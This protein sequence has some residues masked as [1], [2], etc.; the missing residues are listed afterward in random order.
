[1]QTMLHNISLKVI[2]LY[3]FF[4]TQVLLSWWL[5]S[6][7]TDVNNTERKI[8]AS[9]YS[10]IIIISKLMQRIKEE[11]FKVFLWFHKGFLLFERYILRFKIILNLIMYDF[12]KNIMRVSSNL[13]TYFLFR[14]YKEYLIYIY[15]ICNYCKLFIIF[16]SRY[17]LSQNRVAVSNGKRNRIYIHN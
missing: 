10:H 8:S 17:I 13:I 7:L 6:S 15:V 11:G 4:D 1:M 2:C 3:I 9:N 14:R 12:M 16:F 5:N